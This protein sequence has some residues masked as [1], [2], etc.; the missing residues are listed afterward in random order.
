MIYGY[1]RVSTVEQNA[2]LQ[3]T[4]LR[5]AGCKI[6]FEEKR[7]A[8][9]LR[10]QLELLLNTV[11]RGDTVIIYK[12]DR[13]ARSLSHL[14]SIVDF[15]SRKGVRLRSLTEPIDPESAAGRM[16]LQVLGS[17]AEFERSLIR[18]RCMAGQ[19]E[20]LR[21][22]KALGRPSRIPL[23]D[24]NEIIE[25]I[26]AGIPHRAVAAAYGITVYI[27]ENPVYQSE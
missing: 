5:G 14:L 17:V 16:F 25:I 7:S 4:A 11:D 10:P 22:G 8:I 1:A 27:C 15:F 20:A 12:L 13:L 2:G 9:K 6:I 18:E 24:Q 26:A 21:R 23:K 3:V 19:I